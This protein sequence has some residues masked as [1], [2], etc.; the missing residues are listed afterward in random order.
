[1]RGTARK[2]STRGRKQQRADKK[3]PVS[4]TGAFWTHFDE[5]AYGVTIS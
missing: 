4:S 1:L 5:A 3:A 2:L